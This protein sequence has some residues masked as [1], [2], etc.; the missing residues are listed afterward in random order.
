MRPIAFDLV[1]VLRD[2]PASAPAVA[3]ALAEHATRNP[4]VV[5]HALRAPERRQNPLGQV[6]WRVRLYRARCR[7]SHIIGMD[8]WS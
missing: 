4:D 8:G 1:Y 2:W 3:D 6:L 7:S 5:A